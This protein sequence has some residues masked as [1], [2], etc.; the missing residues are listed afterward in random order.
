VPTPEAHVPHLL[1]FFALSGLESATIRSVE[2]AVAGTVQ[3]LRLAVDLV[4]AAI[5]GFGV[6]RAA[7]M[8]ARRLVVGR[9]LELS[10]V[11]LMLV[12]YLALAIEFQLGA[13][14]L[15]TA[16]SPSWDEIGKLAAIAV[17][18]T[19]LNV[20]LMRELEEGARMER[21]EE[22][23]EPRLEPVA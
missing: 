12:R 2:A 22:A 1:P 23:L 3:W 11:R 17:I 14:I 6:L 4:G 21:A 8:L 18:R 20:F 16:V 7:F 10:A 5:V 15:S 13:D 9:T 19:T